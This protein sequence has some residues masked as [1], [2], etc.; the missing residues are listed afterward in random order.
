MFG[1]FDPQSVSRHDRTIDFVDTQ[2]SRHRVQL[3]TPAMA[4]RVRECVRDQLKRRISSAQF[5]R[6]PDGRVTLSSAG[7]AQYEGVLIEADG[8]HLLRCARVKSNGIEVRHKG[9]YPVDFV[10]ETAPM[11]SPMLASVEGYMEQG[12]VKG[13]RAALAPIQAPQPDHRPAAE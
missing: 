3:K 12:R 6:L 4:N 8:A 2:G 11:S 9:M 7:I 13:F 1:I 5:D 10:G